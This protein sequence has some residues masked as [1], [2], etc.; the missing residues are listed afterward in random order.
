MSGEWWLSTSQQ[1]FQHFSSNCAGAVLNMVKNILLCRHY[2]CLHV[3]I[4]MSVFPAFFMRNPCGY[5]EWCILP[6]D[7]KYADGE[8]IYVFLYLF[9]FYKENIC[10]YNIWNTLTLEFNCSWCK[11]GLEL[12]ID[13]RAYIELYIHTTYILT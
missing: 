12:D 4:I 9:L 8:C 10:L 3:L 7:R 6:I 11:D 2:T 13:V 5:K 1:H